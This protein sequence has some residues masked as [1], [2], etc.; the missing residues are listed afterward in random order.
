MLLSWDQH[1]GPSVPPKN[2]THAPILR[3]PRGWHQN[4]RSAFGASRERNFFPRQFC[5]LYTFVALRFS[6]SCFCTEGI[7][8]KTESSLLSNS[9]APAARVLFPIKILRSQPSHRFY[10][11]RSD[12]AALEPFSAPVPRRAPGSHAMLLLVFL[13]RGDVWLCRI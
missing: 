7:C 6:S 4:P 3:D 13:S 1:T 5:S 2:K 8:I 11:E 10:K 12:L 9:S